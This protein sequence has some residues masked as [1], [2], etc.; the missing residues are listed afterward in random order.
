MPCISLRPSIKPSLK[1]LL[2][3]PLRYEEHLCVYDI[4][5]PLAKKI[6]EWMRGAD[7]DPTLPYES[8]LPMYLRVMYN[9]YQT[10]RPS[11]TVTDY[12]DLRYLEEIASLHADC[13]VTIDHYQVGPLSPMMDTLEFIRD[14]VILYDPENP[15]ITESSEDPASQTY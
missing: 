5:E 9:G 8:F 1:K 11:D 6:Y 3:T 14:N 7:M 13:Q 2:W 4:V 10:K 15:E 12:F